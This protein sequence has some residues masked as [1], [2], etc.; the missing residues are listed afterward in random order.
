MNIKPPKS[1]T[2]ANETAISQIEQDHE[3]MVIAKTTAGLPLHMANA[4]ALRQIVRD[5]INKPSED[6]ASVREFYIRQRVALKI[7]REV[8]TA[9]IDNQFAGI[10]PLAG[11]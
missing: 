9:E 10:D 2:P 8:A 5:E 6:H 4:S 7:T 1:T 11:K 3:L